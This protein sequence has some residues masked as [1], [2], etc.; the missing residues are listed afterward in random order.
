[1]SFQEPDDDDVSSVVVTDL[2][3]VL[4]L[5]FLLALGVGLIIAGGLA[6]TAQSLSVDAALSEIVVQTQR[7]QLRQQEE[8]LLRL[9]AAERAQQVLSA[10]WESRQQELV[11]A[12]GLF[13][14]G[15]I[16]LR[17]GQGIGVQ[18]ASDIIQFQSGRPEPVVDQVRLEEARRR[19]CTALQ[20]FRD[21]ALAH[22]AYDVE[23]LGS[24][25]FE[26]L[27]VVVEGHADGMPLSG[28]S[29]ASGN[30]NWALSSNR[31][32]QVLLRLVVPED[33]YL[34]EPQLLRN[35]LTD[36][37]LQTVPPNRIPGLSARRLCDAN[38]LL[39]RHIRIVAAGRGSMQSQCMFIPNV[40]D[41]QRAV[42]CEQERFAVLR[43]FVRTDRL[44]EAF[45]E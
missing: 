43:V 28:G 42:F 9:A 16:F 34:Q 32:A 6:M 30:S 40:T 31:A 2:M 12:E 37:C 3:S 23:R 25:P 4:A 24:N 29:S 7:E 22:E 19:L 11:Q 44:L 13:A 27:E 17:D 35:D 8:R 5:V 33:L 1:M 26:Y 18:L 39:S 20:R 21:T 14:E 15:A 10:A 41:E 45:S 38:C 36:V